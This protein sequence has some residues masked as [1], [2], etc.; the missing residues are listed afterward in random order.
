MKKT[1][2]IM[3]ALVIA[4]VGVIGS[5]SAVSATPPP[6]ISPIYVEITGHTTT[7]ITY[8]VRWEGVS[9]WGYVAEVVFDPTG[10][11]VYTAEDV[12]TFQSNTRTYDNT[13]TPATISFDIAYPGAGTYRLR[14]S[15]LNK[16]GILPKHPVSS[17]EDVGIS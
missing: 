8:I 2:S 3:L 12:V 10:T 14:V 7:N 6:Y 16:R 17:F 4:L 5:A 13:S 1:G 11:P 9:A 15:L